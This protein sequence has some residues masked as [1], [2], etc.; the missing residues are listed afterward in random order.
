MKHQPY[1]VDVIGFGHEIDVMPY[2]I[3]AMSICPYR[4][5]FTPFELAELVELGV[6]GKYVPVG[7]LDR[8][9]DR[10]LGAITGTVIRWIQSEYRIAQLVELMTAEICTFPYVDLDHWEGHSICEQAGK[11]SGRWLSP[12]ELVRL[13]LPE[14]QQHGRCTC[15]YRSWTRRRGK[16]AYPCRDDPDSFRLPSS[17]SGL[18]NL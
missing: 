7:V 12:N 8:I 9:E 14:C 5:D 15:S 17:T 2:I 3:E 10:M 6:R 1:Y 13:P 11:L 4:H 16:E 18:A